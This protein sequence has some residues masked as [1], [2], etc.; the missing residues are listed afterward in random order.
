[1]TDHVDDIESLNE[2]IAQCG[3]F[4]TVRDDYIYFIHYSAKGF[5]TKNAYSRIFPTGTSPVQFS[6]LARALEAMSNTLRH[7][8][9]GIRLPGF[10]AEQIKPPDPDLLGEIR[11]SCVYWVDHLA[12]CNTAI[13][14]TGGF[15][16]SNHLDGTLL[17]HHLHSIRALCD[18]GPIHRFLTKHLLH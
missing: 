5:L 16:D 10:P 4:L 11:C 8:I 1:M 13:K 18:E 9:Y 15:Q 12:A 7:D 17:K 2:I 6:I 14:V 3:S